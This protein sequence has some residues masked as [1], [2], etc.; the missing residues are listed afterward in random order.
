MHG[1]AQVTPFEM[2]FSVTVNIVN[3]HTIMSTAKLLILFFIETHLF[4][5]LDSHVQCSLHFLLGRS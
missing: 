3:I 5:S 4:K 1:L 2:V